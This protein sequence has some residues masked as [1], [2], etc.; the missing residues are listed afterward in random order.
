HLAEALGPLPEG[1]GPRAVWCG[2]AEEVERF[3]DRHPGRDLDEEVE[4]WR[5]PCLHADRE[6]LH[7]LLARA[8]ELVAAGDQLSADIDPLQDLS[9]G[10]WAVHLGQA[11]ELAPRLPE[12]ALEQGLGMDLGW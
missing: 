7:D 8:P 3:A 6:R 5:E 9:P 12:P 1:P 10:G 4:R 2:L 11:E